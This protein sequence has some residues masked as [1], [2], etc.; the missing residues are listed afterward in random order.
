MNPQGLGEFARVQFLDE[1][2][3]DLR[4]IN[5][6]SRE[7]VVEILRT[8]KMF[9]RGVVDAIPLRN[10]NKTGDLSDCG[11]LVVAIDDDIEY[12]IVVREQGNSFDVVEVVVIEDR[13]RDLPYLLAGLRL[14]RLQDPI[15]R[16]DAGRRIH[17]IRQQLDE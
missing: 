4:R 7:D 12:R 13:T 16:S 1:A 9:D 6:R 5:K 8:L 11:K 17:R 14:N 15:R 2:R 10:F 3:E